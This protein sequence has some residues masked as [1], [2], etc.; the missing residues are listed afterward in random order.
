MDVDVTPS[1]KKTNKVEPKK[2]GKNATPA[3]RKKDSED[4]ETLYNED[5]A[6]ESDE[7]ESE[8]EEFDDENENQVR[9]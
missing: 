8:V 2:K 4:E 9:G 7:I 5:L 6:D 1:S 3:S